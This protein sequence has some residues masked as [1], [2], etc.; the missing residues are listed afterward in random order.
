MS[1]IIFDDSEQI[2][3]A[4][5]NVRVEGH[6]LL[7]DSA[8]RRKPD[9]RPGRDTASP[10]YRRAFVH[11]GNDGLTM[12]FASDYPGGVTLNSMVALKAEDYRDIQFTFTRPD[13]VDANGA[14]GRAGTEKTILLGEVLTILRNQIS[15]LQARID[16]LAT[17]P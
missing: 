4:C 17:R 16:H 11:D 9:G 13:E 5:K 3:M 8:K 1:D 14:I 15:E 12:N 6:D 2:I 10:S 7:L